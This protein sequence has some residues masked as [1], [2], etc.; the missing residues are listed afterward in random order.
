VKRFFNWSIL[1]S[2]TGCV[3]ELDEG[4]WRQDSPGSNAIQRSGS[5][6]I[7]ALAFYPPQ[8]GLLDKIWN[9]VISKWSSEPDKA[10]TKLDL[11]EIRLEYNRLFVGPNALPCPP[12]E[13]VYRTDRPSSELGML[14]GP[15]VID[16]KKRYGEAGLQ[17]A[18]NFHDLPDHVSVEMEFMS[19]LCAK[20]A[21]A[22]GEQ[23]DDVIWRERQAEFLRI[24]LES[25]IPQFSESVLSNCESNFYRAAAT[26]LKDWIQDECEF[27]KVNLEQ[28]RPPL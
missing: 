13:S 22:L 2:D 26:F 16:V 1:G 24:H 12:Y 28:E 8:A 18:Q 17:V 9:S 3:Q 14:M 6:K 4:T 21:A 10:K 23:E 15:S 11:T 27:F 19:F 20:E 5:Y 7:L 25:W